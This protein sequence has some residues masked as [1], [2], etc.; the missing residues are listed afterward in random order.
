M[1]DD[2]A[3]WIAE[4]LGPRQV[5]GRYRSGYWGDDYAVLAVRTD[6]DDW[7]RW[8][9]TVATDAELAEGGSRTHCTRWDPDH[10]SVI[11]HPSDQEK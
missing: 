2:A 10:D 9:I 1:S 11:C 4:A 8:S 7:M 3:A 5:G 6:R